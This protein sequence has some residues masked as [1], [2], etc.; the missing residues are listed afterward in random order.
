M[1]CDLVLH[2]DSG[3]AVAMAFIKCPKH[4]GQIAAPFC[5]HAALAIAEGRPLVL[6]LQREKKWGDWFTLCDLCVRHLD[7]PSILENLELVCEKCIVEWAEVT[8]SDYVRRCQN[9]KPEL[10]AE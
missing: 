6:Y 5:E 1:D 3:H 2:G 8:N 9:P 4:G 10:P 7:A